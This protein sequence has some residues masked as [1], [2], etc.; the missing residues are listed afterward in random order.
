MKGSIEGK[1]E[2]K[3]GRT[4][5]KNSEGESLYAPLLVL[6]LVVT[7]AR[8]KKAHSLASAGQNRLR[9]KRNPTT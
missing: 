4:V 7:K 6:V 2:R 3:G 8:I 5:G 9:E 1:E